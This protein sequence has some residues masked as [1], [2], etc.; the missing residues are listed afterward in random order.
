MIARSHRSGA[1]RTSA[2]WPR[3]PMLGLLL[4][5]LGALGILLAGPGYRAEL[6][7]LGTAFT[8]LR[9]GVYGAL[10]GAVIC[11]VSLLTPA[12]RRHRRALQAAVAGVVA[13]A[14]LVAV[15]WQWQRTARSVPPIHDITTD[16]DDPPEFDAVRPLRAA[17]PNPVEYAGAETAAQQRA[18]YPDLAPLFLPVTESEA[19]ARA[20]RA[21]RDLGWAIV[22]ADRAAG[23]LEATDTTF[24]FGFK[25][26][27]VVRIR[28]VEGGSRIDVRS[29]SRLGRSD[30]GTNARRIRTFLDRVRS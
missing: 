27:V 3:L 21:A 25:D 8:I 1:F 23:R 7:T 11:L 6:W 24:W 14:I 19:F 16:L 20:E 13:G 2:Q 9:W 4:V 5:V 26:D 28:A 30:V 18:A 29:K 12:V 15:P 17:A 10:A 22:A